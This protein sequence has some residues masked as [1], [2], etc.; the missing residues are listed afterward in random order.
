MFSL[1]KY[2]PPMIEKNLKSIFFWPL[3]CLSVNLQLLITLFGLFKPFLRTIPLKITC[4]L[5]Y[6]TV[7]SHPF[8]T[9]KEEHTIF[10][11]SKQTLTR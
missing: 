8:V 7:F 4:I 11:Q 3:Y 10:S 2:S 1:V 5:W 9:N 6:R